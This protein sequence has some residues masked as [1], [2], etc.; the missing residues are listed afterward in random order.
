MGGKDALR[1]NSFNVS[2]NKIIY[3]EVAQNKGAKHYRVKQR[4]RG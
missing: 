3:F 1:P 4:K 2:F